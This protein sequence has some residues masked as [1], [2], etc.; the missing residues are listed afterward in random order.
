[1]NGLH[2]SHLGRK[3]VLFHTN[4]K[5]SHSEQLFLLLLRSEKTKLFL[6]VFTVSSE[7]EMSSVIFS[8]LDIRIIIRS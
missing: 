6:N 3:V 5:C 7:A 1:M 2:S 8:A 4:P